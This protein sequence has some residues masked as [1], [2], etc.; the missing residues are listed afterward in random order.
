VDVLRAYQSELVANDVVVIGGSAGSIAAMRVIVGAL[1]VDFPAAV[2]IVT[3]LARRRPSALDRILDRAGSLP[4]TFAS[5]KQELVPGRIY[6]APP[7]RHLV[8]QDHRT[9]LIYGPRHNL[10]RPAIDL[11]FG[12]AAESF[13]RH[14]TGVILSGMLDDGAQGLA[15]IKQRGGTTVV[16]DPEDALHR[17]MPENALRTADVDHVLPASQIGSLLVEQLGRRVEGWAHPAGLLG[18]AA[19]GVGSTPE[20]VVG[21]MENTQVIE[22]DSEVFVLSCPECGGPLTEMGE[23]ELLSY[24]C[25]VGHG[26]SLETLSEL[27]HDGVER[28]LWTALRSMRELIALRRRMVERMEIHNWGPKRKAELEHEIEE[29]ER[30]VSVLRRLLY[31]GQAEET[32]A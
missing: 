11:L 1:P 6:L 16:Q 8:L 23:K 21:I 31:A 7:E 32:L 5:D 3:H 10:A 18:E 26:Y 29:A 14:V 25:V 9:R 19:V 2:L 22:P 4:C 13:G 12:S 17:D 24:R 20:R 28:A 15:A 27:Q 30:D